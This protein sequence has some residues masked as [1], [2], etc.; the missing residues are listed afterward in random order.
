MKKWNDWCVCLAS[1]QCVREYQFTHRR[2][3][4]SNKL[5]HR[6]MVTLAEGYAIDRHET[7]TREYQ[8]NDFAFSRLHMRSNTTYQTVH[9]HSRAS[10]H[11]YYSLWR[12]PNATKH[13]LYGDVWQ[14]L[15]VCKS[16]LH[17]LVSHQEV[18]PEMRVRILH[19]KSSFPHHVLHTF[20]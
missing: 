10:C 16:H 5:L 18:D 14:F 6:S 2:S 20:E 19:S 8:S 13:R 1:H 15:R 17:V 11:C 4:Q 12:L 9:S 3:R 7:D